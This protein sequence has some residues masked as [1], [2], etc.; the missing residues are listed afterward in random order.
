MKK[1]TRAQALHA[2]KLLRIRNPEFS[3]ADFLYGMNV[4]LEHQDVTH[5][6]LLKSAKIAYAHLRE[7]P[8]YYKYLR[9]M[10]TELE[11]L[12]RRKR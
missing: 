1:F 8:L 12:P 11:R 2:A 5:G 4:E 3:L 9:K 6:S 10:E 7:S